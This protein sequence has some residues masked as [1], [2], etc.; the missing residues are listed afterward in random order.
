MLTLYQ[1]PISHYCE[2][3]RWALA[4]KKL[5]HRTTNLLPG[6]H[7]LSTKKL[8]R[9]SA[10]P[11]LVHD[12]T[13]VQNS[14]DIIS[15]LDERFPDHPLTPAA[16]ELKREALDWE[17]FADREI[18]PHVRRYVY[19]ILLDHPAIVTPLFT[20]NGPWY[21]PLL[22]R[23]MYPRLRKTMRQSMNINSKTAAAS[24]QRVE[25]AIDTLYAHLQGR[26]FLA[27]DRFTRADLA[28]AALLAPLRRPPEYGLQWPQYLP[29]ELEQTIANCEAKTRWVDT[30]YE[31]Y[32]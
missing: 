10:V 29:D 15:Y 1:F 16:A 23:L 19:S 2:K 26:K 25:R 24:L 5:V 28:A 22:I 32:R 14:S 3:I 9:D 11:I 31:T 13:V 4:Y 7:I 12:G 6:L 27:G 18:G 20:H 17:A 8:S 30:L 21:G